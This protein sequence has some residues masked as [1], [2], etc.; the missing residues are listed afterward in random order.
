M[1][2]REGKFSTL[3]TLS[4]YRLYLNQDILLRIVE[5]HD[6]FRCI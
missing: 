4:N 1:S 3:D 6:S 2:G 5:Y